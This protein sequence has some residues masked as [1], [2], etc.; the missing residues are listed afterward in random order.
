MF[1]LYGV[2]FFVL[3]VLFELLVPL[4]GVYVFLCMVLLC[5]V[6]ETVQVNIT[7]SLQAAI[8]R[9]MSFIW[10]QVSH[11]LRPIFWPV[12]MMNVV[13]RSQYFDA[14]QHWE[15]LPLVVI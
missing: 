8:A 5:T 6:A 2:Y 13:S 9:E 10:W 12:R 4:H 15:G 3:S 11:F 14:C 1:C 7:E